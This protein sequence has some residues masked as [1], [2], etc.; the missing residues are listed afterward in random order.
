MTDV[1]I[2]VAREMLEHSDTTIAAIATA[3]GFSQAS[4]FS[5]AFVAAVSETPQAYRKRHRD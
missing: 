2:T 5:R 4:S 3:V 1:R